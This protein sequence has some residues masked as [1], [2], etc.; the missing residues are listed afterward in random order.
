MKF[1]NFKTNHG[2]LMKFGRLVGNMVS[3]RRIRSD[4][5]NITGTWH[6]ALNSIL[7]V[8]DSSTN[9]VLTVGGWSGDTGSNAWAMS[10]GRQF[11][12][13]DADHD[14]FSG[15]C[16]SS[17]GSGFWYGYWCSRN[18]VNWKRWF[19][20]GHFQWLHALECSRS[21]FVVLESRIRRWRSPDNTWS[22]LD[23][24]NGP[25]SYNYTRIIILI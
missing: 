11:S 5:Q 19:H 7:F 21:F 3:K 2:I 17:Y 24:L 15:N 18:D 20:V 8:G 23:R 14:T 22:R 12:T 13:S 9:Y 10:N 1:C 16:A 25:P 4:S 6:Y